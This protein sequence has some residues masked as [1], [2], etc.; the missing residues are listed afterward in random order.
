MTQ[1]I[2]EEPCHVCGEVSGLFPELINSRG[3]VKE[4]F[5]LEHEVSCYA[6]EQCDKKFDFLCDFHHHNEE[7]GDSGRQYIQISMCGTFSR[8]EISTV[9]KSMD[10]VL[11]VEY[12]YSSWFKHEDYYDLN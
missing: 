10:K 9:L 1:P 11:N 6:C 12:P 2:R 5:P 3:T 7:H 4:T 8:M